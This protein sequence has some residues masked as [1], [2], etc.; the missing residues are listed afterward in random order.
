MWLRSEGRKGRGVGVR[1]ATRRRRPRRGL[2]AVSLVGGVRHVELRD[3]VVVMVKQLCRRL[4]AADVRAR[5]QVCKRMVSGHC[6]IDSMSLR[7]DGRSQNDGGMPR[8]AQGLKRH[9][10]AARGSTCVARTRC[11]RGH[12]G[13]GCAPL[14]V[15]AVVIVQV[16]K[17]ADAR[18]T[19]SRNR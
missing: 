5:V 13:R 16:D 6:A 4:A 9:F 17:P 7:G 12:G 10:E 15:K 1:A 11:W 8:H 3:D 18:L 19:R 14:A 2:G